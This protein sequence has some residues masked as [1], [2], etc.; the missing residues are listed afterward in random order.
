MN[1]R[2]VGGLL[3]QRSLFREMGSGFREKR[4]QFDGT[5]IVLWILLGVGFFVC[6][7]L[8]SR[9]VAR[10]DQHQL[11]NSPR[12]LLK[13]LCRAHGLDR[14]GC[15]L[16]VEIARVHGIEPPARVFLEPAC[17][18]NPGEHPALAGKAGAIRALAQRLFP[19]TAGGHSQAGA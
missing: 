4:E 1:L 3:A 13:S 14:A 16:L 18:E 7:A 17:F 8:V 6:I 15:R 11:F 19:P 10:G 5:D 2:E 9:L 12:R